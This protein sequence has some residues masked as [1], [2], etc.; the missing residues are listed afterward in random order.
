ME[1]VNGGGKGDALIGIGG[2]SITAGVLAAEEGV[3][4]AFL[5][6]NPAG[7]AILGGGFLVGLGA[8]LTYHSR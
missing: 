2:V 3:T 6:S 1:V 4:V 7:W 5:L 8:Y